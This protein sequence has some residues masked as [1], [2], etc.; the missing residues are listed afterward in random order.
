LADQEGV[1]SDAPE[2][3]GP[4]SHSPG[5]RE[6]AL[7][8]RSLTPAIAARAQA[9]LF[10][11]AGLVGAL[12]VLLPHPPRFDEKHMLMVQFSSVAAAVLL[13]LL[14]QFVPRWF[15][16]I[17]PYG[18]SV[19]TSMAVV[20]SGEGTSAYLLF[21]LW[22]AF[23]AFYFLPRRGAM[24][25]AGFTVLNYA[26]VLAYFRVAGAAH[27]SPDNGD[28]SAMVLTT[29]TVA[30]SG[31]FILLLR[32]RVGGL[33]RQLTEAAS[34]D[35]LTGLL[36]RRG[37]QRVIETEL[38]RSA[39][40]E[41]PFSLL[42]GDCDF[43]KHLNDSLGHQ[44]GDQALIMIGR[45]L[46]GDKRRVDV[47]ARIGGEEFALVLPEADHHDA[48]LTAERLRTRFAEVF[49]SQPIPLTMSFGVATYGLH[50]TDADSLMRAADEAL[51][52]AK[53]LGRDRSVLH[54]AEIADIL[55]AR[56]DQE[57]N[58]DDA[59]LATVVNLA[60]ALDMRDT[61]TARHSQTVGRLSELMGH[62]L[63]LSADRI[64]RL[65]LAGLLH[66]IGKIG[67]PDSVLKKPGPLTPDERKQ[68]DKHPEIGARI[69]GG[70]G[71]D[72]I[73]EWVLAH[74]E[75]PDGTGYPRRL[76]DKE[77]PL[78]AKILA[79]GDAFEAMTADRVYR[80]AIGPE[81]ARNELRACAG[82]QFDARVVTAFLRALERESDRGMAA[83]E[84]SDGLAV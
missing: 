25:L 35:H 23:Y 41:R 6:N 33:I 24:G 38:A 28:I 80:K 83:I 30:V 72:D 43:F 68:M 81:A 62:E 67:V 65:R 29:G 48:Y 16:A 56:K 46:E 1:G 75:R 19:A 32:E 10:A 63:G 21:Y 79:V 37:F 52:A 55:A 70:S 42:L 40:S 57:T 5:F 11:S 27:G 14:P 53:A 34:T 45:M 4:E 54:S 73:R 50:G 64:E 31:V 77:I 71:L 7:A 3:L 58:G 44:A 74:H 18:A 39:R 12:G 36:N 15:L 51:Y 61:G 49:A 2:Q 22:V 82:T 78:E 26:G 76:T 66:D 20:F 9:Y 47:P 60:Q 17:G 8:L 13:F 69:L 59:Q 84:R